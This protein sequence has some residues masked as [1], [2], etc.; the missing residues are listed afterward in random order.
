MYGYAI[1]DE[2]E[3]KNLRFARLVQLLPQFTF[4]RHTFD[5]GE[6]VYVKGPGVPFLLNGSAECGDTFTASGFLFA[7]MNELGLISE[8]VISNLLER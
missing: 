7:Q 2:P 5:C 3:V 1:L 4:T 8:A 6:K